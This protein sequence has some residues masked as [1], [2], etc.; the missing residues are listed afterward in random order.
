MKRL[1]FTTSDAGAGCLRQ[2]G[3]ADAVMPV[4][5]RFFLREPLPSA[6]I[7]PIHWRRMIGWGVSTGSTLNRPIIARAQ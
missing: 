6:S 4:G 5:R 2:P 3:I 1:I 7:L